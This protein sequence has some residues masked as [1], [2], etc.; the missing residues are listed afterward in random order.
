MFTG[1]ATEEYNTL[2]R[3]YIYK[4]GEDYTPP[5]NS[6]ILLSNI[7][8]GWSV[9]PV[10][11]FHLAQLYGLKMPE[12]VEV[13]DKVYSKLTTREER[14][15]FN[16]KMLNGDILDVLR[17]KV[18]MERTAR[19]GLFRD[20]AAAAQRPPGLSDAVIQGAPGPRQLIGDFLGV[21]QDRPPAPETISEFHNGAGPRTGPY[22]WQPGGMKRKSYRHKSR[23]HKSRKPNRYRKQRSKSSRHK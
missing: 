17:N 10:R 21:Q 13:F 14:I 22:L 4:L 12:A 20:K 1:E 16:E 3:P 18:N 9:P 7:L 19:E 11:P 23:R 8:N 6:D 2:F 5:E 15:R